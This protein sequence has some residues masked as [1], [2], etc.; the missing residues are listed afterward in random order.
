MET[1]QIEAS[2]AAH[3]LATLIVAWLPFW[4]PILLQLA[5]TIWLALKAIRVLRTIAAGQD[6]IL[7]KLNDIDRRLAAKS[8]LPPDAT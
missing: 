6:G 1:H 3:A 5:V 8:I 7:A 4:I 2:D